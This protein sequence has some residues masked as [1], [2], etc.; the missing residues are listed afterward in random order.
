MNKPGISYRQ[1]IRFIVGLCVF[2][3]VGKILMYIGSEFFLGVIQ[4]QIGLRANNLLKVMG[5]IAI[6]MISAYAASFVYA[7][8]F[9]HQ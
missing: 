5:S 4:P 7:K 8:V 6:F 1:I 3:L 9:N 2:V